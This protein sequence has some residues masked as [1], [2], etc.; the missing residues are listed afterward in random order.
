[1]ATWRLGA[2]ALG[3]RERGGF[4]DSQIQLL[5]TFA[6]QAVIAITS[7]ETYRALQERTR[8]LTRRNSEYGERI[9]QQAA[10]IDVLKAMSASPGDARPV[11]ELIVD[12]ARAFCEADHATTA[13]L[14]DDML[15]LQA[16]SGMSAEYA[17]E[18][19]SRFPRP[20]DSSTMFGRAILSRETMQAPNVQ[21]DPAL[22]ASQI[23]SF[24]DFHTVVGVPMLRGGEPIGAI[25]L[26][27]R[28]PGGFSE[29][30][31][32]L[33]KTFA[34]QAVIAVVS[35]ET[36]RDLAQRTADLQQSL[37][38]QTATSE[39]LNVISRSTFDLEPVFQTVAATAVRLCNADQA[40]IYLHQNNEYRW[41][42]GYSQLP[43]YERIERE[44]R[45]RPGTGT[46]VGRVAL[47]SRP[48]QILDAW[49]DTLYE[50]KADARVGAIHTL[51]GVPLLRDGS[52]I[53][54][55]GLGRQNIE[56]FTERQIELVS[57]FAAQA[58]I[59]MENARLLTEQ[60]EA[61]EQ[62]TA[63]AEVL[64]V[65]NTS[66]GDLAP[67]F[68]AMLEK[69]LRLCDAAFGNLWTYDGEVGRLA[70]ICGASPEYR[71]ELMRAGPQKPEP[72]ASLIR[73]VE[74]E[75]LVH[76]ADITAEGAHRSGVAVRRMLADRAGARTVLWV[77][78]RKDG[79]LLGFFTIYRTEV[80]PFTDKQI[81]LLENFAAQAVIAMENARLI[82]ETREALEQQTATAE[83]LQVINSSP[84]DLAPVFDAMLE[85]A[86][87]LCEAA[88]GS[89]YT[90]DGHRFRSAAQRG[91]PATYAAYR[92]SHPPELVGQGGL[93]QA[94][95][96]R[97]AV[98]T[99]DM[100]AE[101][102]YLEGNPN[103]RAMVDL[104]GI[105]TIAAVPLCK[106]E[107][108]LGVMSIYRQ[109]VR[110]YSDRQIALLENF[111]AQAVIAMENARLLDRAAGGTGTANRDRRGVAGHQFLAR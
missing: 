75:P 105:R 110:P 53:G 99:A 28:A 6:E 12:R 48:V 81:A 71:A 7:A 51:L 104:G 109:E 44:V 40:G 103:V 54:V 20:V 15:H 63:T 22:F 23:A 61:L 94:V 58:V 47:E 35:A 98:Q 89:L 11:F 41:A 19:I 97:R 88:F 86:M 95:S 13:L 45:I 33:L 84:G 87:C 67:V 111:A 31:I 73:L 64:Q 42:G 78:M 96:T 36:Y 69:A 82:N 2:L 92:E 93:Q 8:A 106:D 77:P 46:L 66:P 16:F 57:T 70:A 10:T 91:V 38:Y 79:A 25:A 68:D 76:I 52:P 59:A 90:Y 49:T 56:P 5:E 26:G 18:Y 100:M 4:T 65:I 30:Q 62:Q 17:K 34:E 55:I 72:G 74:G 37:E 24:A 102:L 107:T 39:V 43:E 85:K 101:R 108:V 3:S 32:E 60:R 83:V 27:R 80:R 21:A 29:T 14:R 50:A 9:E 1:M